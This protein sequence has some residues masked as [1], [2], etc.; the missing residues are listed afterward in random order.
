MTSVGFAAS[1]RNLKNMEWNAKLGFTSD[2]YFLYGYRPESLVYTMGELRQGFQ[3]IAGSVNLRNTI[4]T[5]YGLSYFPSLKL[6]YFSGRQNA[7][8]TESNTVLDLPIKKT[9][10]SMFAFQF[11]AT[12]DLTRYQH[13]QGVNDRVDVNNLFYVSPA[14]AIKADI[15]FLHAGLRPSWDNGVF[16]M[17]P[18][19]MADITTNDQ[20][21]T[22]QLGWIGYYDKGSYQ[23]FAGM[24]PWLARP[25]SLLNT[26]MQERYAG[27][28]G[29]V[30]NHFSYSAKVGFLQYRNV[31]LLVNDLNDGKSFS[32]LYEERMQALQLHG[33]VEYIHGDHFS[34]NASVNLNQ[35]T[36]L[37]KEAKA[38]G[39]IP[40]EVKA[41]MRWQ[42]LR[43]LWLRSDLWAFTSPQFRRTNGDH[44]K[45]DG[46][47]DV[48]A[49]LEF[50]FHRNFNAW[51]QMNNILD[52]RYERWNQYQVFGFHMM[53]GVTY[54]FNRKK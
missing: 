5:D 1:H 51:F 23:R 19:L 40:L 49:G 39:M 28:K 6:S 7:K 16:H 41:G 3:T 52:S 44:F 2:E 53:G 34:A 42:V 13:P 14:V 18:N 32:V 8:A 24:N 26:R 4:P 33:E 20:R 29:S 50:R 12:A 11:S 22:F 25:D 17:L 45:G 37:K 43:D 30:D 48:S 21:F 47:F 36:G 9:F 31:P 35:Y 27:F 15:F 46:G 10:G 54:T 38:W